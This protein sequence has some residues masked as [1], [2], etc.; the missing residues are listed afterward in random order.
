[1]KSMKKIMSIMLAMV[2][3]IAM[4]IPAFADETNNLTINTA[5]GHTYEI[6]QMLVGDVSSLV[7][8]S[9]VLAN[10]TAGTN[11]DGTVDAF[12]AAIDGKTGTDL[13]AAALAKIKDAPT[14][15]ITGDGT[16]KTQAVAP[17][18]YVVKDSYTY[19]DD[20]EKLEEGQT[21]TK[22]VAYMVAVVGDTTMD[23]KMDVP[24]IDKNITDTDANVALETGESKKT[25][26]AAIGDIINYKAES[27]VPVTEGY[28][29]YY[30]V[31]NDTM[32]TGLT[33]NYDLAITI[34]GEALSED[35]YTLT[36]TDQGFK[37]VV[38]D[39]KRYNA[40]DAI[41]ITYSATVNE[42]AEIGTIPNTN[43]INLT[44]SNNP[45][46]T[47]DK[48]KNPSGE[49]DDDDVVGK[50]P[51]RVTKTYVTQVT[52]QKTD[53]DADIFLAALQGAEF[54]LTGDGLNDV[55]LVTETTFTEATNGTYY[56]LKD[57]TYTEAAPVEATANNKGNADKYAD[58][59]KMY[60]PTTTTNV[61]SVNDNE[62]GSSCNITATVDPL[63]GKITFTGL[64]AGTYKIEETKVPEGY[65]KCA[66]IEFT[67]TASQ[68]GATN[69]VGGDIT[70][71]S[72]NENVQPGQ[73]AGLFETTIENQTGSV[74]PS[75]GGMGTTLFYLVGG[76][77]VIGAGVLL[78]TKRRM[79]AR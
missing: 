69:L 40:G 6:Y 33:Y 3:I 63:T 46:D 50:T 42:N 14:A 16:A 64:N 76:I 15:T 17:G 65:N 34:G 55:K 59:G 11:L 60:K 23:P 77:L 41:E 2:M 49:P 35:E 12:T 37:L 47:F 4:S 9:G 53:A 19:T 48:D 68:T 24:T 36:E 32:S 44:Y 73:T 39:M 78:I 1:M 22:A 38:K 31:V 21:H 70:W 29:Y 56:K 27:V 7:D 20:N 72:S 43:T 67:L 62:S 58:D 25:D 18:Y 28:K 54:K 79:E 51:D 66:D 57:G 75:T 5:A 61:V 52:I 10:V 30:Y 13:S 71:T 8:G 26:T 74:L 45:S